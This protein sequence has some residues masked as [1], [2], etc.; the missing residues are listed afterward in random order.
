MKKLLLVLST[1]GLLASGA[2]A[3]PGPDSFGCYLEVTDPE[4]MITNE[5]CTT[6]AFLDHVLLHVLITDLSNAQVKAWEALVTISNES[7]WVGNWV[8]DGGTN[9][10][11]PPEFVVGA[12][13]DPIFP[14]AE[15]AA[16]LMSIDLLILSD[17]APIEVFIDGVPGS[18]SFPDG[19]GYAWEAG[20]PV[21]CFTS[22]GGPTTPVFEING[23]CEIMGNED[24]SWGAV[25]SLFK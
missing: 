12:G 10:S 23:L 20:F 2:V 3:Y 19:P 7:A 6:A 11:T 18:L 24:A 5:I 4:P 9:Y 25:K 8:L 15:G 21:P 16:E 22:T 17:V 14:N 13:A 1:I